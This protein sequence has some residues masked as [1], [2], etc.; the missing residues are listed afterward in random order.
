MGPCSCP[1]GCKSDFMK[2]ER[3]NKTPRGSYGHAQVLSMSDCSCMSPRSKCSNSVD[4]LDR[5]P[6]AGGFQR[7][8]RE[9]GSPPPA[10]SNLKDEGQKRCF[11][12]LFLQLPALPML[13]AFGL[14][15]CWARFSHRAAAV[16]RLSAARTQPPA[17]LPV[18]HSRPLRKRCP[19]FVFFTTAF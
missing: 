17:K 19:L 4:L 7:L 18:W 2:C 15:R 13:T 10:A 11:I 1:L 9:E 3:I 12:S 16:R 5:L 6:G 14:G 8:E